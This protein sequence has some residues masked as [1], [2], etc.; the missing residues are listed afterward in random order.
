MDQFDLVPAS[1]YNKSLF[2]QAVKKQKLPK[3]QISQNPTY[4]IDSLKNEINKILC[5]KADT[6]V[7]KILFC[8]RIKLS[9]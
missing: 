8:P 4:Q 3:C 7:N 2:A 1:V 9:N 6:L 5:S